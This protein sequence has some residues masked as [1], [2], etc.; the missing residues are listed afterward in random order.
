[1]SSFFDEHELLEIPIVAA[2]L[3]RLVLPRQS[4]I[5]TILYAADTLRRLTYS[6]TAGF[7][8]R[9]GLSGEIDRL[10]SEQWLLVQEEAIHYYELVAPNIKNVKSRVYQ[11]SDAAWRHPAGVQAVV[12][13]SDA[14][15]QALVV[16]YSFASPLPTEITISLHLG[17]GRF[18]A[19]FLG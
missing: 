11:L 7:L 19:L 18:S 16:L 6:L 4:Q 14:G 10:D 1:M 5:W 2:N 15:Y 9:L 3:Q 13:I 12:R 8:G 17:T